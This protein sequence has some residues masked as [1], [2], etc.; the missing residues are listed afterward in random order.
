[1]NEQL[2]QPKERLTPAEIYR[3]AA[4][5]YESLPEEYKE[6]IISALVDMWNMERKTKPLTSKEG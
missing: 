4:K 3:K 6:P 1:M 2:E 5:I